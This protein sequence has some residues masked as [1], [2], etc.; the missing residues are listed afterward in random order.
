MIECNYAI[1]DCD[2][3]SPGGEFRR[4]CFN[5]IVIWGKYLMLLSLDIENTIVMHV[6]FELNNN[7]PTS[8]SNLAEPA[9]HERG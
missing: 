6:D 9:S 3:E 5:S 2:S 8:F 7:F 1:S 4:L